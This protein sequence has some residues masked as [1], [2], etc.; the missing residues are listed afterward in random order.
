MHFSFAFYLFTVVATC[1]TAVMGILMLGYFGKLP[2]EVYTTFSGAVET[3]AFSILPKAA[4]PILLQKLLDMW[5]FRGRGSWLHNSAAFALYDFNLI[6][7][8]P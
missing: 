1:L 6:Y 2:R 7:G 8:K 3:V 5:F 4:A